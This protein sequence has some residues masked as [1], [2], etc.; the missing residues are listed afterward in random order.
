MRYVWVPSLI[1]CRWGR[2]WFLLTLS[3]EPGLDWKSLR[4]SGYLLAMVQLS[5]LSVGIT[6]VSLWARLYQWLW[7]VLS[8]EAMTWGCPGTVRWLCEVAPALWGGFA[9]QPPL[10]MLR[11]SSADF[12]DGF[13]LPWSLYWGLYFPYLQWDFFSTSVPFLACSLDLHLRS[14]FWHLWSLYIWQGHS[15]L[16]KKCVGTTTLVWRPWS[17]G[18]PSHLA[19]SFSCGTRWASMCP[20]IVYSRL[21]SF[22]EFFPSGTQGPS[23]LIF[24][25]LSLWSKAKE[26]FSLLCQLSIFLQLSFHNILSFSFFLNDFLQTVGR[27]VVFRLESWQVKRGKATVFSVLRNRFQAVA[28]L[29]KFP[30]R[31]SSGVVSTVVGGGVY[32]PAQLESSV[33]RTSFRNVCDNRT[34]TTSD[35]F[36]SKFPGTGIFSVW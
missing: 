30:W 28:L 1:V 15:L 24:C 17:C 27:Y 12:H 25:A 13:R 20:F 16:A 10:G 7:W 8:F 36:L 6:G 21:G 34:Y 32:T 11:T 22:S 26:T 18:I 31:V 4:S 3:L 5:L 19:I 35:Q 29:W 9:P 14:R 23:P 33:A 2:Q